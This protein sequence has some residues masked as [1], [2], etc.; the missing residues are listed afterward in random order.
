M[1]ED[2]PMGNVGMEEISWRSRNPESFKGQAFCVFA[3][4]FQGN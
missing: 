2:I 3:E 4:T 1:A